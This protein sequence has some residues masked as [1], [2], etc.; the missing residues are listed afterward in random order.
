MKTW[1]VSMFML[2]GLLFEPNYAQLVAA[3]NTREQARILFNEIKKTL[4]VSP[5]LLE[6]FKITTGN[7]KCKLN[8]NIL[9]P[10]AA[11]ARNTDG[12]LVSLGCVDEYGAARDDSIYQSIQT[13]MLSTINRLL[14]TI[15]TGYPYPNN[16]MKEQIEYGKKVL[17]E[18]IEDDRFFLMCYELDEKDDWTDSK[19]WI[20]S[21]PLQANSKLG[22]EFLEGECKMALEMPSKQVAFRTKNLNQWLDGDATQV[23]IP[24]EDVK[25]CRIDSYDWTD[26]EVYIG[27]DLAQTT[28]NCA[29]SMVT[30]DEYLDKYIIK[31]WGFIPDGNAFEKSKV[32]KIDYNL[33]KELNYCYF[34]GDKVVDYSYIENF[35]LQ[36]EDKY[37]VRIKSIAYD[38]YNCISTATKL[39]NLGYETIEIRQNSS[40]LHSGTKLLKESVLTNKVGYETNSLL[41][42][43]F[44]NAREMEDSNLKTFLNKKKSTGKI[45]LVASI[46]NC[47]VLIHTDYIDVSV[48][49]TESR[50]EGFLIL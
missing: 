30:Y 24:I 12:M 5:H 2:L 20:K 43:N 16:P 35:I 46:I 38:R 11:E 42:I 6:F 10:I 48:Y 8:N 4:E 14:F 45:D 44:A 18:V 17:D 36:L 49:E 31:A 29:V 21:N 41:E 26:R 13:S 22:M 33:F 37:K 32:E 34:C 23:Y 47:F 50:E 3:A 1:L 25:K 39:S 27:I 28:D 40:V 7:I 15:S 9:F 19:V